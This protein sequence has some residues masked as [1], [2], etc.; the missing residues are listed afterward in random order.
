M[1]LPSEDELVS[2]VK[3]RE[4]QARHWNDMAAPFTAN[5]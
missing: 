1:T 5:H 2:L 3:L 4:K